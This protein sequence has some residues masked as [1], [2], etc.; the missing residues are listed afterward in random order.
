[1]GEQLQNQQESTNLEKE[2]RRKPSK[3]TEQNSS[4]PNSSESSVRCPVSRCRKMS[5]KAMSL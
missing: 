5:L 2:V 4:V 3:T 1:M